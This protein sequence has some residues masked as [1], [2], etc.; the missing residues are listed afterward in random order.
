MR[1][2]LATV[3]L[4]G[5]LAAAQVPATPAQADPETCPPVCDQIPDTAW[6]DPGAVPLNGT[7]R[8]PTLARVAAPVTGTAAGPR[9]RFEELC[10]TTPLPR[11]PREYAVASRAAVANPPG[12]WQLQAQVLHWRGDTARGGQNAFSVLTSAAAALRGCQLGA[13]NQSAAIT[14]DE[15]NRLAAVI[16]GPVI[17]HTYLVAE[18]QNSSL[19]ELSLWSSSPP[20]TPWPT[21]SD[22]QVLD[23]MTGP[24]CAA[25]LGSCP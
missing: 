20:Q 13:P 24:L 23:A 6:I 25:Y 11:D 1:V 16:S 18:P 9:F 3:L 14:V 15:T 7:Y 17:L 19:S 10:A 4:A 21:V 2:I 22:A 8:W 12:Q 5:G